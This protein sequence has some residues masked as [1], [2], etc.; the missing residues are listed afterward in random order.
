VDT[1]P[2]VADQSAISQFLGGYLMHTYMCVYNFFFYMYIYV[3]IHIC[4]HTLKLHKILK[5]AHICTHI[6]TFMYVCIYTYIYILVHICIHTLRLVFTTVFTTQSC[7]GE[8]Y[9]ILH[10]CTYVYTHIYV[11]VHMHI[12]IQTRIHIY[13][14]T[15]WDLCLLPRYAAENPV[16]PL[17]RQHCVCVECGV[18]LCIRERGRER[19]QQM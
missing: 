3:L 2:F 1:R 7:S 4:I 15:Y 10:M 17:V 11:R 13:V 16:K 8:S 12:Y 18:C 6:H 14:Y 9:R 5:C 19:G